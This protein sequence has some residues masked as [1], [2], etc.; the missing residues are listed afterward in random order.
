MTRTE[1]RLK[2]A[3]NTASVFDDDMDDVSE[4]VVEMT[5]YSYFDDEYIPT[6][7]N[8]Y[9]SYR[10]RHYQ[11]HDYSDY[12]LGLHYYSALSHVLVQHR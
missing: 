11:H 6:T 2:Q 1:S 12:R 8:S 3:S 10:S 9:L 7:P 4:P 5:P